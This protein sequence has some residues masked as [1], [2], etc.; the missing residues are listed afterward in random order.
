MQRCPGLL[1]LDV[2]NLFVFLHLKRRGLLMEA[3]LLLPPFDMLHFLLLT[4]MLRM[5]SSQQTGHRP[6]LWDTLAGN[7]T[8]ICIFSLAHIW[9]MFWVMKLEGCCNIF[10]SVHC[11]GFSRRAYNVFR[12]SDL[13]Y[14]SDNGGIPGDSMVADVHRT[15]LYGGIFMYPADKKSPKGKLR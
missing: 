12:W 8:S 2:L 14:F 1:N 9:D 6:S 7:Y 15:L 10:W 13:I 11:S 5:L 4:G 3:L